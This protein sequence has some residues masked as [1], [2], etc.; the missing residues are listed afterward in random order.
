MPSSR[1]GR[2]ENAGVQGHDGGRWRRRCWLVE[3][4]A[5]GYRKVCPRGRNGKVHAGMAAPGTA[6]M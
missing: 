5:S 2:Q 6:K 4:T 1:R 3:Q